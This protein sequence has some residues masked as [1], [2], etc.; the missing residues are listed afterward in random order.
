MSVVVIF[1]IVFYTIGAF[2]NSS[3]FLYILDLYPTIYSM[4][5]PWPSLKLDKTRG[6]AKGTRPTQLPTLRRTEMSIVQ[7]AVMLCG[8]GV[9]AGLVIP[10][11]D[12]MW[13]TWKKVRSLV[14][15]CHNWAIKT[16][17]TPATM[18]KQHC[19][20]SNAT[21]SNVASTLLLVCTGL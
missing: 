12:N 11:V 15:T 19:H 3:V 6:W 4:I 13:L 21:K 16:P 18:S 1:M 8:W 5:L 10:F 14:N 2:A 9:R 17:S 20:L 7:S